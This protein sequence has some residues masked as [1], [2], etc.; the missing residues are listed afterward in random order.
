MRV[1]S[2]A[3]AGG[4]LALAACSPNSLSGP[5]AFSVNTAFATPG[6]G[7]AIP[8]FPGATGIYLLDQAYT[9]S[10]CD[11]YFLEDNGGVTEL[12]Q[13][14]IGVAPPDG[15]QVSA[16]TFEVQ[17]ESVAPSART[18]QVSYLDPADIDGGWAFGVGGSI[19]LTE[20]GPTYAGSFSTTINGEKISGDFSVPSCNPN[21]V[22]P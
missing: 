7:P 16:G 8:A 20:A 5:L 15:G 10:G 3:A 18:A 21:V 6:L 2:V 13:V 22:N 4:V 11:A 12:A 1:H 14:V 9:A 19:T 17:G